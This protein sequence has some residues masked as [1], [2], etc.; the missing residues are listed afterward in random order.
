[1]RPV[2]LLPKDAPGTRRSLPSLPVVA[3]S[4]TPVL[5]AALVLFGWS[6][7]HAKVRDRSAELETVQ[8]QVRS[9]QPTAGADAAAGLAALRDARTA[10][11]DDVLHRR[12]AWD[13]VLDAIARVLPADV[14]LTSMSLQSATPLAGASTTTA[15]AAPGLQ[16]SGSA[17]SQSAVAHALARLA[18]VP[19]LTG[20]TLLS[21]TTSTVG[22][23]AVVQFQITA[24]VGG[25][26]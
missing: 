23:A 7:A 24:T 22:K 14:W 17:R 1:M 2:N 8:A 19:E 4:A 11:A 25:A 3:V 12:V 13:S 9:V 10:A 16:L 15:T 26:A 20:T 18:L 21:T 5:A 6:T